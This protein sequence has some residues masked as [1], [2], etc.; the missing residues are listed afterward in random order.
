MKS[1]AQNSISA[2]RSVEF[3]SIAVVFVLA[4]SLLATTTLIFSRL[5]EELVDSTE[6]SIATRV[7]AVNASIVNVL[8]LAADEAM[9]LMSSWKTRDGSVKAEAYAAVMREETRDRLGKIQ[10]GLIG[11]VAA[12]IV[13]RGEAPI[14]SILTQRNNVLLGTWWREYLDLEGTVGGGNFG[15]LG[16]RRNLGFVAKPFRGMTGIG[17]IL[18][19]VIPY[20]IGTEL[21]MT[22]FFEIDMTVILED[23]QDRMVFG[24]GP[25]YPIELSF[26]DRE[27]VLVETTRNLPMVK[28]M[29]FVPGHPEMQERATGR[30]GRGLV[31]YLAPGNRSIE[32]SISDGRLDMLCVGRVPASVVMRDVRRVATNVLAVGALAMLAVVLLGILLGQAFKRARNFEKEQL[33]ARFEALQAKINPHFLFNTLD[34]MVGLAENGERERLLGMIRSLSSM[35]HATV[36]RTDNRVTISE[37]LDYVRAYISIQE[38]R[39]RDRFS[40]TITVDE[41]AAQASICRFSIQPIVENCFTHGVH[42]GSPGMHISISVSMESPGKPE[43]PGRP[44]A[45]G[46][47]EV[48]GRLEVSGTRK[49]IQVLVKDDG[50]GAPPEVVARLRE[51][52]SRTMNRTG[53]EGG[54][55]NVHDRIRM[56]YGEPYGLQLVDVDRGFAIRLILPFAGTLSVSEDRKRNFLGRNYS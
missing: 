41:L 38:V 35:L 19:V 23:M 18:P 33:I 1:R 36:R 52:F 9:N 46:R 3:L 37:E 26:Y 15:N 32:A 39:Y 5:A 28:V 53:H 56:M 4:A 48:P 16:I 8:S 14:V 20:Y 51:S 49:R 29:P 40:C 44:E 2:L 24:A 21:A 27:G 54:L 17:T 10:S 43:S 7:M 31:E 12:W 50:P 30:I 55:F 6:S 25:E 13:P 42:E 11:C 47:L 45:Q 22:A 34:S